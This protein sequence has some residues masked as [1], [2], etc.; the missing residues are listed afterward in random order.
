M[1]PQRVTEDS[2]KQISLMIQKNAIS[3]IYPDTPG[4]YWNVFLVRKASGGWRP[5]TD[6]KQ[7]NHH[8]NAPH[9][10]NHTIS[11]GPSTVERGDY[12]LQDVYF[13]VLIHPDSRKYPYFCLRKQSISVPSTSLRSEHCPQVFICFGHT[14]EVYLYRKGI[15]VIPYL[16]DWLI[17]HPDCQVLLWHQS[18]LLHTLNMV[19][20]RLN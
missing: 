10:H 19:G 1:I 16:D 4:F 11:S 20:L 17:H 12:G 9:F 8:I 2:G 3:E 5:V 18:Q 6:L 13:Q 15:L 7:L 14:V